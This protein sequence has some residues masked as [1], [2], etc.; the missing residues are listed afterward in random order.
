MCKRL[1]EIRNSAEGLP[2]CLSGCKQ[3]GWE[4]RQLK[5]QPLELSSK[6]G[7]SHSR[8]IK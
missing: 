4:Y 8:K 1:A 5:W 3:G 2:H 6:W 7:F